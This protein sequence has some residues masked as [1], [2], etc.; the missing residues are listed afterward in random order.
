MRGGSGV[1][2]FEAGGGADPLLGGTGAD[3]L[4]GG[5]GSDVTERRPCTGRFLR[6]RD[7][8]HL[9]RARHGRP[10]ALTNCES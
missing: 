6:F 10:E 5:R 7:P 4:V 2:I 8:F 1:D 3:L 9:R